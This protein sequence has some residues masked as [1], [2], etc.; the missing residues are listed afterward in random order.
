MTRQNR[1][2]GQAYVITV[3]FLAVLLAMAA[4]V[5]DIGSWYRAD[6]S[7]Q[8]TVDAAA[9]AGAQALPTSTANASALASQYATK[10]GGGTINVTFQSKVFPN[11]TIKVTGSRPAP[12]F[13][14]KVLGVKSVTV[15]ANAT[16]RAGLLSAAKWVVPIVVDEKHPKLQCNPNPCSGSTELVYQ[17]FKKNGSPDG[18]GNFG[19]I[20]ITGDKQG[21]SDLGNLIT[22]GWDQ[23]MDIG[24]YDAITGNMFSSTSIGDNL[25]ARIGDVL[26]FPIYRKLT[27]SGT[28]A[29]YQIIGWAGFR[30]TGMDLHG[31][32]EKLFGEFVSVT[33]EGVQAEKASDA[34]QDF[35][36]KNVS[37]VD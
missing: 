26:L 20:N 29:Q 1:S 25:D 37:L 6:R 10:N 32:N 5:L 34:G 30:L 33:W 21:T 22:N 3:L 11:D 8:A 28:G 36:V 16:A 35:G 7:L 12:G 4:A 23:F 2:S 17:H 24:N 15:H 13:F 27:G 31:T 18:S 19:F 14:S 9:L